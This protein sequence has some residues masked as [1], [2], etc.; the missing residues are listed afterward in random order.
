[1]PASA[2]ADAE[3][4]PYVPST[5]QIQINTRAGDDEEPPVDAAA[6]LA[7]LP[8]D[9]TELLTR[10]EPCS[11]ASFGPNTV[12]FNVTTEEARHIAEPLKSMYGE[13]EFGIDGGVWE[14][15]SFAFLPYLPHS[16]PV[17]CCGG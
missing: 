13:D 14:G 9:V 8:P 3:P 10:P 11:F 12:C 5:Y 1:L 6:M 15:Y 2:W 7:F 17:W 4:K 16:Q